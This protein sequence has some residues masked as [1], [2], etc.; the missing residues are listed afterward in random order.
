MSRSD[1]RLPVKAVIFDMDGLLIDSEPYWR[2]AETEVLN[3]LGVPIK[4]AD[5]AQ[6]A[7]LRIREVVAN[8]RELYPWDGESTESVAD[9]IQHQL[10]A[11]IR[12]SGE[13][14]PGAQE[15]VQ[16]LHYRG[17]PLAI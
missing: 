4:H 13:L 5:C 16:E 3:A 9:R 15:L 2:D 6:F 8:W 11:S 1:T 10:C 12:E 17:Y 7:G 14:L